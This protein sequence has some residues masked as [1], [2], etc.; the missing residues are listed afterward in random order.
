MNQLHKQIAIDVLD[1]MTLAEAGRKNN[2]SSET[3]GRVFVKCMYK[4]RSIL[5]NAGIEYS[6]RGRNVELI[7]RNRELLRPFILQTIDKFIE[8]TR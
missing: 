3:A 7:Y 8:N 6:K 2:R 1:G 4:L 5:D